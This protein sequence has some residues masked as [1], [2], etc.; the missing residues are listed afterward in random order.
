MPKSTKSRARK[1]FESRPAGA[2][3]GLRTAFG[4]YPTPVSAPVL[5]RL[6]RLRVAASQLTWRCDTSFFD[7]K[8]TREVPALKGMLGQRQ[9]VTTLKLGLSMDGPGYNLFICGLSGTE[10]V[11]DLADYIQRL[12]LPWAPPPDRVWSTVCGAST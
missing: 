4:C 11:R 5:A 7:F 6:R 3:R 9:A 10:A 1:K 2:S 12:K 8:T